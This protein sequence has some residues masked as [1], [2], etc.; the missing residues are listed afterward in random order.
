MAPPFSTSRTRAVPA[1]SAGSV[2]IYEFAGK[3]TLV[4]VFGMA[5]EPALALVIVFHVVMVGFGALFGVVGLL[6]ARLSLGE[7][8]ARG[9]AGRGDGAAA[10]DGAPGGGPET[11]GGP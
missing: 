8:R 5:A 10:Y 3:T 4:V 11:E 7:I 2:G 9:G 6:L 1:S